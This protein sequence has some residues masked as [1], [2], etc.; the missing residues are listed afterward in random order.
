MLGAGCRGGWAWEEEIRLGLVGTGE[1]A[2][3]GVAVGLGWHWAPVS[4]AADPLRVRIAGYG[5]A[6]G[7]WRARFSVGRGWAMS[8]PAA[9]LEAVPC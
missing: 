2:D 4:P 1:A 3:S 5:G 8:G 6:L 7:Y 9:E